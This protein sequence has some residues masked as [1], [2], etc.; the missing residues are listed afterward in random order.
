MSNDRRRVHDELPVTHVVMPNGGGWFD[1]RS[2]RSG[3][4]YQ[5]VPLGGQEA[6]CTCLGY[7]HTKKPCSHIAAVIELARELLPAAPKLTIEQLFQRIKEGGVK[8]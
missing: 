1:V 4:L 3:Q 6:S 5:V 7:E 2:G 8:L